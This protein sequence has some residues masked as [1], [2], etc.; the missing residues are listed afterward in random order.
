MTRGKLHLA[1]VLGLVTAMLVSL[2]MVAS[3]AVGKN[4]KPSAAQYQYKVAICHR[5]KSKKKPFHAI[6][7]SSRSR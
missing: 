2:A 5:T 6:T 4:T 1:G 7:V 3:A